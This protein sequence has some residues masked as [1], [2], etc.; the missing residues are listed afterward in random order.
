MVG[1]EWDGASQRATE[2]SGGGIEARNA[3]ITPLV[4]PEGKEEFLVSD[5]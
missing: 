2:F 1:G 5:F 4:I 3:Q